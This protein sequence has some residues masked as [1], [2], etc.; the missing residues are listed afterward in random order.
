MQDE[1]EGKTVGGHLV[2]SNQY[3]MRQ[4]IGKSLWWAL[5]LTGLKFKKEELTLLLLF[6]YWSF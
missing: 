5:G 1:E 3:L 4:I 6:I 2:E